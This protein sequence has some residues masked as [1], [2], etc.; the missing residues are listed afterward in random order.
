MD[1]NDRIQCKIC[2]RFFGSLTLH[3]IRTHHVAPDAYKREFNERRIVSEALCYQR[4]RNAVAMGWGKRSWTDARVLETIRRMARAG[5][6][7]SATDLKG[8]SLLIAAVNHFRSW[9]AALTA[10]GV[11]PAS[12]R[13]IEPHGSWSRERVLAEIAQLQAAGHDLSPKNLEK[14]NVQLYSASWTY[15][16][17]WQAALKAVWVDWREH[18]VKERTRCTRENTLQAIQDEHAAGHSLI[19]GDVIARRPALHHAVSRFFKGGWRVAFQEAGLDPDAHRA[20]R[21][22]TEERV[23]A[24]LRERRKAGKSLVVNV[25]RHE[26]SGLIQAVKTRYG[27]WSAGLAAAGISL[28]TDSPRG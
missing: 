28:K 25:V 7:L 1:L 11:D 19:R 22:W 15:C 9:D 6:S 17:G 8:K 5:T 20:I 12:V 23:L 18:Y 16:G 27:K 24:A 2:G 14:T 13:R 10:A 26:D 3:L 21:L 4:S